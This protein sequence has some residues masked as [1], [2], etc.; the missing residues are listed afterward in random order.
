M[1]KK[2]AL[3][4]AYIGFCDIVAIGFHLDL[5]QLLCKPLLMPVLI[6]FY[7][8][9]ARNQKNGFHK[10]MITA[11]FFSWLGDIALMFTAQFAQSFMLG[12]GAFLITH[13][14]YIIAFW[15]SDFTKEGHQYLIRRPYLVIPFILYGFALIYYLQG[16]LHEMLIPV[17]IYSTCLLLMTISAF[18]RRGH[19]N[20][21]SFFQ[22]FIGAVLFL[23]S[24]SIIALHQ[25]SD[26]FSSNKQ[27]PNIAIMVLYILGQWLLANGAL[28]KYSLGLTFSKQ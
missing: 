22:I 24:D 26:L 17:V 7:W 21:A 28:R 8:L 12:L 18:N 1:L 6:Y 27:I 20:E 4:Y 14:L 11:F 23:F 25:F 13:I 16:N 2:I 3:L 5:L 9:G 19:V 10:L 15:K